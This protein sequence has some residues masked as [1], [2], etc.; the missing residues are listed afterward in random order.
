M[1]DGVWRLDGYLNPLDGEIL[2]TALRLAAGSDDDTK[3]PR[4]PAQRRAGPP[5]RAIASCCVDVTTPV[6]TARAGRRS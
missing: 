3:A 5:V 4:T 2:D 6:S 1:F